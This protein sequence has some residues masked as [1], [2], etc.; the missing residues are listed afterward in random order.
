[1]QKLTDEG[2]AYFQGRHPELVAAIRNR[3]DA[4]LTPAEVRELLVTKY[5]LHDMAGL[6][7]AAARYVEANKG[8]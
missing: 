3:I 8:K 2:F 1:M 5:G 7:E 4:G 6:I